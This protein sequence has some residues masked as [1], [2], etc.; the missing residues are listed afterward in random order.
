MRTVLVIGAGGLVGSHVKAAFDGDR[1]VATY[2]RTIPPGGVRLDVTDANAVRA[3]IEELGPDVVVLSAAEPWVDRCER[4]P[5]ATRALNVAPARVI[6]DALQGGTACL[7]VFSSEY[8][9]DG[10]AGAYTEDDP[11][12]P[13]NEYGRQKVA[14]EEAARAAP[15][16]LICRTSGV[17]GPEQARKNFVCQLVDRLREGRG[18]RVA[19]DQ[20]ITPTYAS[21]LASAVARLAR[22]GVTG[23]VHV[24]GPHILPRP[25]FAR[26]AASAF[27]LAHDLIDEVTTAEFGY[28]AARPLRAGLRDDRLRALL[29]APLRAPDAAL[30]AMRAAEAVTP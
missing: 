4:E 26:L 9:F 3:A 16:H 14:L 25:A 13:I 23:T 11:V 6:A 5:D 15:H 19:S 7:V 17:Y 10:A 8:V 2:H 1:I 18:F 30:A 21:D 22:A 27:G 28:A 12:S 24:A 29:G 20:L